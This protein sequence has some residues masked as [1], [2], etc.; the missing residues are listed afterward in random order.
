MPSM[1]VG[2][3]S[4]ESLLVV[5]INEGKRICN[6]SNKPPYFSIAERCFRRSANYPVGE[7]VS[8]RDS[9]AVRPPKL[10]QEEENK[11][12]LLWVIQNCKGKRNSPI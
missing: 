9:S 7:H 8:S 10:L 1:G 12:C 2:F 4:V 3:L 11:K 5:Y 6:P